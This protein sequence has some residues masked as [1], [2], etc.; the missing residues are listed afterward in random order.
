[1]TS[2][3]E[4][5]DALHPYVSELAARALAEAPASGCLEI[6]AT[7]AFFDISGF[8][9]ITERLAG[10]GR[11][12]AEH[13]NDILNLVFHRLIDEVFNFGGDVLEFGG[14]AMVVFFSDADHQR[15]A[16][17]RVVLNHVVEQQIVHRA[18]PATSTQL[19]YPV[20][21]A[22]QRPDRPRGQEFA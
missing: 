9:A 17:L 11:P 15:R 6:S 10:L 18:P 16:A 14:D 19:H 2:S 5:M 4:P 1:M 3:G 22:L 20:S 12:G 21:P 8:T 7:L 13:I